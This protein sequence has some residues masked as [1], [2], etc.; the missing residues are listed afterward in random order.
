MRV[1][2]GA[3]VWPPTVVKLIDG[4]PVNFLYTV[5]GVSSC[6]A[7]WRKAV[8]VALHGITIK[9]APLESILKSNEFRISQIYRSSGP[10]LPGARLPKSN[11]A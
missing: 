2:L 8:D 9:A 3:T 5:H 1:K 11:E 4:T 10:G 7:E 6:A